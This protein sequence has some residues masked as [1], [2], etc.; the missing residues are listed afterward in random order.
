MTDVYGAGEHPVPGVT[1]RLVAD[2]AVN[3]GAP[4]VEYLHSRRLLA[5]RLAELAV[6]G[7]LVLLMGAG[8][9]TGAADELAALLEDAT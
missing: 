8:D 2:A 4:S 5:P 6:D 3:A 7:D 9:I 1:G